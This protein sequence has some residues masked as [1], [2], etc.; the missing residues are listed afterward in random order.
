M[1]AF[2]QF[3]QTNILQKCLYDITI[4]DMG[5]VGVLEKLIFVLI[6]ALL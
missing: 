4:Y 6:L 3:V 1:K 2:L 5:L